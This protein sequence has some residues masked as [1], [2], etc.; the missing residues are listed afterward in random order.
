MHFFC[1][2][3]GGAVVDDLMGSSGAQR[4]DG[5]LR[6]QA[7]AGHFGRD[8]V[9]G[10]N[11]GHAGIVGGADKYQCVTAGL[12]RRADD[13]CTVHK[14]QFCPALLGFLQARFNAVQN[15]RLGDGC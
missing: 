13:D 10:T 1:Q 14:G 15:F 7:A 4:F 2:L 11:A 8:A 3:F 6:V 12:E 9:T 5:R